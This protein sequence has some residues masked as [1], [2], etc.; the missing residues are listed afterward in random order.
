MSPTTSPVQTTDIESLVQEVALAGK[1]LPRELHAQVVAVG[2]AAVPALLRILEDE[3]YYACDGPGEGFGCVHAAT[4]LAE[5]GSPLAVQPFLR[6]LERTDALDMVYDRCVLG[7][8]RVAN[9]QQVL[10]AYEST[11]NEGVRRTLV[12]VLSELGVR[13]ERIYEILVGWLNK[14]TE[15]AAGCLADYGDPRAIDLLSRA[16]DAAP[17]RTARQF[18]ANHALVELREAIERLGGELTPEQREKYR[19]GMKPAERFRQRMFSAASTSRKLGRNEHCWC[20]SGKKYKRCHL[21]T[22]QAE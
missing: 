22:D 2:D 5:I 10:E 16:F 6:A 21:R 9:A 8:T 11:T 19:Q 1:R 4:L 3:A 12:H 17:V 20:G 15:L 13:D 14:E 18:L 7:L